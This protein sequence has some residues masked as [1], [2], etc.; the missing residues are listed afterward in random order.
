M[1][2]LNA[3][4]RVASAV[5][6]EILCSKICELMLPFYIVDGDLS[7]LHEILHVNLPEGD[8]FEYTNCTMP[9]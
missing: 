9:G 6:I 4:R 2:F 1:L 3:N 7:F 8:V 5:P